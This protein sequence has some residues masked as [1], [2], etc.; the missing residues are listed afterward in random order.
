MLQILQQ[1]WPWYVAGALIGLIV[2]ALL[3]LGNKHFGISANLRHACAACFP[4]GIKFFRYDWK[5]EMWNFFFVGGILAGAVI[6]ALLLPNPDPVVVNPALAKELAGYG[7]TSQGSLLPA[8]LFSWSGLFSLRGSI[9]LVGGG[10]LVGFG[11]RYA[12]GCTSGHAIMGL[13]NLQW[14]SLVATVM[15]MAGGFI[16]ANLLLPLILHL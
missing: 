4:A 3:L 15:F 14:P 16:T 6:T 10:F 11:S 2:P 13:S 12:G 7:I 9:L 5:K 1:P 8:E